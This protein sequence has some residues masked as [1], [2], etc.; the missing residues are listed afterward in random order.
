MGLLRCLCCP[1]LVRCETDIWMLSDMFV[2]VFYFLSLKMDISASVLQNHTHTPVRCNSF[3]F[4]FPHNR[5]QQGSKVT[6]FVFLCLSLTQAAVYAEGCFTLFVCESS[7]F[8][9]IRNMHWL[10]LPCPTS[11]WGLCGGFP[12]F[13]GN[14]CRW[15]YTQTIPHSGDCC[16][17]PLI[18]EH[19]K[20]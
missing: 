20:R 7:S 19:A 1:P 14:S 12:A 8:S 9:S 13:Q 15:G 4:K 18:T 6:S 2:D 5:T 11:E 3:K 16:S 10:L 17:S